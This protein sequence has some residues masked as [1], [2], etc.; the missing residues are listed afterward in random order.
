MAELILHHY[1]ESL[2]SEKVRAMLGA[3]KLAWRSVIIPMIAPRPDTIPLTGGYRRTPVMQIG[4]D[5]YC[6]TALIAVVLDPLGSGPTFYPAASLLA[7]Q[8]LARWVDTELFWAAVTLRFLPANTGSFFASNEAAAAFAADRAQF[9]QGSTVRRLPVAEARPRYTVFL[10]ELE[11]QLGDGRAYLFGPDW[12]IADFSSYH[13]VWF[14]H[15]GGAMADLLAAHPATTAWYGRM[16]AFGAGKGSAMT[17]PEALAVATASD[18]APIIGG[19]SDL[20]GIPVGTLVDVGP[21]DYG[22][23]PSR[24]ELLNCDTASITIRRRHDRTGVVHVHFPR[25]GFGVT[26]VSGGDA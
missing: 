4:A 17:G 13:L 5:V 24:G 7:A 16:K 11:R 19:S 1:P 21:T 2:F 25:H 10:A 22:V 12:T 15:A 23:M 8:T 9:S 20:D 18:S 26:A 3:R 14:I 6:D